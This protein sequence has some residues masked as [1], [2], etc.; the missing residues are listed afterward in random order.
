MLTNGKERLECSLVEKR[1]VRYL[2]NIHFCDTLSIAEPE[3]FP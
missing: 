2:S 3:D 1:F